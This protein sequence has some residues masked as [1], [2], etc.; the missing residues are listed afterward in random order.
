MKKLFILV[1]I[2]LFILSGCSMFNKN[3]V[4]TCERTFKDEGTQTIAKY[5]YELDKNGKPVRYTIVAGYQYKEDNK[6]SYNKMCD[7]LKDGLKDERLEKYKDVATLQV[8]CEEKTLKAYVIKD[9]KVEEIRKF[10]DF[11]GIVSGIDKYTKED[12][13][14]NLEEWKKYFT[15][16]QYNKGKYECNY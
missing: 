10:E 2:S 8:F 11:N 13:T 9:Y 3:K 5:T 14:F 12:G 4:Y 7:G 16:G 15:E 6:D 1:L